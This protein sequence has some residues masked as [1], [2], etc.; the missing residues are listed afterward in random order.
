[1]GLAAAFLLP[2]F[3]LA[4][5]AASSAAFFIA[6]SYYDFLMS[7]ISFLFFSASGSKGTGHKCLAYSLTF[8]E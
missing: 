4:A 2:G 1:V 6:S 8:L 3:Y 5:A 7:A